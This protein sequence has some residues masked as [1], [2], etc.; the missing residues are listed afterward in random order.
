MLRNVI[1]SVSKVGSRIHR[2]TSTLFVISLP[3]QAKQKYSTNNTENDA[4]FLEAPKNASAEDLEK[5]MKNRPIAK[6]VSSLKFQ[7][8]FISIFC[9]FYDIYF[10]K[11]RLDSLIEN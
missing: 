11:I 9:L 7:I 2:S 6:N 1:R 4:E 8:Y 10:Y 3:K 5:W